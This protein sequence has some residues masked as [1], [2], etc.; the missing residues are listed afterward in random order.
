[1][2]HPS[3][4]CRF[5]SATRFLR[6]RA[7]RSRRVY[8]K[9]LWCLRCPPRGRVQVPGWNW[10]QWRC[11]E[12]TP[13]QQLRLLR[14]VNRDLHGWLPTGELEFLAAQYPLRFD[15][16]TH[17]SGPWRKTMVRRLPRWVRRI[18]E[19]V[20]SWGDRQRMDTVRVRLK[21]GS[22]RR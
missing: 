15:M 14:C 3:R 11:W 4:H 8:A 5:P 21:C 22:V 9:L 1:M 18:C 7:V 19:L 2:K 17:G 12:L 13:E 10:R 6:W 20:L 16:G